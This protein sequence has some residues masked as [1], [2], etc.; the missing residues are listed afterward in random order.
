MCSAIH[1]LGLIE[2]KRLVCTNV[3]S[4]LYVTATVF[5]EYNYIFKR[6]LSKTLGGDE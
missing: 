1:F 4:L 2:G 3:Y 6:H 5:L